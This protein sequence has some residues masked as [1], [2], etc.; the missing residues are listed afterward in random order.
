MLKRCGCSEWSACDHSWFVRWWQGNSQHEKGFKL[1]GQRASEFAA[2]VEQQKRRPRSE[3]E[4]PQ[5][6]VTVRRLDDGL[7]SWW[8]RVRSMVYFIRAADGMVKIGT[9]TNVLKRVKDLASQS[10][11]PLELVAVVPGNTTDEAALHDRFN[12]ARDH[13]EWFRP[14]P[15]LLEFIDAAV[16]LS[17][18]LA[19]GFGKW[20]EEQQPGSSTYDG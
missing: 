7:S 15:E 17:D 8:W 20:K 4:L 11:V 16:M 5:S 2:E 18:A 12:D 14:V 9:S 13:G 6:K 19:Y 10:P 3:P 1:D